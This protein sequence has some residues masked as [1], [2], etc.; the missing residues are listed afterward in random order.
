LLGSGLALYEGGGGGCIVPYWKPVLAEGTA[1]LGDLAGA[2]R[3]IDEVIAQVERP[4]WGE[5]CYYPEAL[6]LKGWMHSLNGDLEGAERNFLASLDWARRQ[7]SK[8]WELRTATSLARL[9]Q[10]Q[11]SGRRRMS[12]SPRFM[13]GSPRGLIRRICGREGASSRTGVIDA[14]HLRWYRRTTGRGINHLD[15]SRLTEPCSASDQRPH[16]AE[17]RRWT[18]RTGFKIWGLNNTRAAFRENGVNAEILRHLTADDLKDLGVAAVGHRR[19]LLIAITAL[20]DT[21]ADVS[22]RS[23]TGRT[24]NLGAPE[25][26]A[27]RRPL[28]VMFCDLVGSTALSSRLD[29]ED[30]QEVIRTYQACV[31]S[32]IKEFDGFVARYVGDGV[33]IY[34]GWP[35]ARETDSERAVRAGLAVADAVSA[36]AVDG[37]PPRVSSGQVERPASR[38]PACLRSPQ[39]L[40]QRFAASSLSP[41][42]SKASLPWVYLYV[43]P[44]SRLKQRAS[45]RDM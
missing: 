3:L 4:G 18:S 14:R 12:Y 13:A 5:R 7:Q 21:P 6:R 39:G 19:Q 44:N 28:S 38:P 23:A 29:P 9:W 40:A 41:F 35:M 36:A 16:W 30:L 27:E 11:A 43:E 42:F 10:S 22:E 1:R 20:K 2:L 32:T 33:L 31:A 8:S 34:F 17:E 37:Q 15:T 26:T 24:E 45:R 25:T